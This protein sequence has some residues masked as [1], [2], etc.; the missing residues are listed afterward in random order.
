MPGARHGAP[1][2]GSDAPTWEIRMLITLRAPLEVSGVSSF[3]VRTKS[4]FA[5][6]LS[7]APRS[8]DSVTIETS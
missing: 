7:E 2:C 5:D 3:V 1:A 8:I 4:R 6:A